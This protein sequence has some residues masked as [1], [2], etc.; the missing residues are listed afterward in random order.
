MLGVTVLGE[1]DSRLTGAAAV[2]DAIQRIGGLAAAAVNGLSTMLNEAETARARVTNAQVD[3][4]NSL[5]H[6]QSVKTAVSKEEARLAQLTAD[7]NAAQTK[8]DTLNR[9]IA[10]V[11]ALFG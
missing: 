11:K 8:L 1:S 2:Q 7:I 9:S 3:V 6:L 4:T 5:A 10:A